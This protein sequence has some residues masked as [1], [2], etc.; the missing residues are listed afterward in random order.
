MQITADVVATRLGSEP[1][2]DGQLAE[3]PTLPTYSS[4]FYVFNAASWDGTED[5]QAR[6]QLGWDESH[7]YIAVDVQDDIHVQT[8][9]GNQLFR[10]DS[11]DIQF[12]TDRSG[13]FG[14]QLSPDD[15]QI[16][17]SPGD[18]AALPP[19]AF[20]FRG[21]AAGTIVDAP[22]HSVSVAAQPSPNGYTL[23]AAIPWADLGLSPTIGMTIG[24]ALNAN[25]NDT[26]G[27]A[28][29]EVMMSHIATRTLTDP[30]SWGTLTLR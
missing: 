19:S 6:W 13:D 20:R 25:D 24:L 11:V 28:V 18:F 9:S 2:I 10:G 3:W 1:I 26:P 16:T 27:T 12:D 29:Q 21:T 7:L 30:T 8:Q 14:P 22:G 4:A 23:E 17:L 5:L 15:Y